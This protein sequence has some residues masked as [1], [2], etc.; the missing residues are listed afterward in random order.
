M[1]ILARHK[2]NV[3]HNPTSNLKLGSGIANVP[4]MLQ[5]GI[6]VALGTDGAASNNNLSLFK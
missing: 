2:V 3:I 1:G 5:R 6:N 4:K